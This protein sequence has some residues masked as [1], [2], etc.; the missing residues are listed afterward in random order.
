MLIKKGK[1]FTL[2]DDTKSPMQE[3]DRKKHK[4]LE[5][6]MKKEIILKKKQMAREFEALENKQKLRLVYT[7]KVLNLSY[8]MSLKFLQFS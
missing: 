5:N 7:D 8:E 6:R 3:I 4:F 1:A 2:L